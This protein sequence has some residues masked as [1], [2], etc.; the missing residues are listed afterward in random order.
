VSVQ[1]GPGDF[2]DG[3]MMIDGFDDVPDGRGRGTTTGADGSF[4]LESV[5]PGTVTI[6]ARGAT[7]QPARQGGVVV[8]P[9]QTTK[10]GRLNPDRGAVAKVKVVDE[11]GK[12]IADAQVRARRAPE[13]APG[14]GGG[15]RFAARA[16]A[17]EDR[18]DGPVMIGGDRL[19][20]AKTD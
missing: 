9:A 2:G 14:D 3:V 11:A 19:T 15:G 13:R 1:G 4:R 16:M 17:F 20:S 18:G 8:S 6:V 10:G 12:P 7:H 5:K